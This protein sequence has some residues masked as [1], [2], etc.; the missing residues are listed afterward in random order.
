LLRDRLAV[1]FT[2]TLNTAPEVQFVGPS[3]RLEGDTVN[4]PLGDNSIV[5]TTTAYG[6]TDR[7][8]VISRECGGDRIVRVSLELSVREIS[9][10]IRADSVGDGDTVAEYVA[11]VDRELVTDT[12]REDDCVRLEVP[13]TDAVTEA[14]GENDAVVE[15]VVVTDAVVVV[16]VVKDG[17]TVTEAV[18]VEVVD[19][20]VEVDVDVDVE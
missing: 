2:L 15:Y 17:E 11:E 4:T 1:G 20:D 16:V 3:H 7:R 8:A 18:T 19:G 5:R 14:V 12:E 10:T 13:V 9:V 6:C